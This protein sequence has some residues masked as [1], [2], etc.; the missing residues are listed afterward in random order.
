MEP[1]PPSPSNNNTNPPVDQKTNKV[2]FGQTIKQ[3]AIDQL[4]KNEKVLY[5]AIY[6]PDNTSVKKVKSA[7]R[8]TIKK[9]IIGKIETSEDV[10]NKLGNTAV[11]KN[12]L[13]KFKTIDKI[14][15]TQTKNESIDR[16]PPTIASVQSLLKPTQK[17]NKSAITPIEEMKTD[18]DVNKYE[19]LPQ[20]AANARTEAIDQL[21]Q[22]RNPNLSAIERITLAI[23][24]ENNMHTYLNPSTH[25]ERIEHLKKILAVKDL[26]P[27][28]QP[29]GSILTSRLQ[30]E[31]PE[32][33]CKKFKPIAPYVFEMLQPEAIENLK[34]ENL[35]KAIGMDVTHFGETPEEQRET[36]Q[37][38]IQQE[39]NFLK[40]QPAH[41]DH[42]LQFLYHIQNG[43][44]V[45][46]T[47]LEKFGKSNILAAYSGELEI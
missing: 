36:I 15:E 25:V 37:A 6:T 12:L 21:T 2:S 45:E 29:E 11:G 33:Y 42:R 16:T 30:P 46:S 26:K 20:Y 39:I 24:I 17:Q 35:S 27:N 10:I 13:Q 7:L 22:L 14:E 18:R 43:R 3:I 8:S 31:I 1:L 41:D 5:E 23:H 40:Q 38:A 9:L 47:Y 44:S 4:P 19:P 34:A 32:P 28:I